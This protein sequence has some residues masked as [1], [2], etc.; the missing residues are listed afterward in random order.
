[1]VSDAQKEANKRWRL[2]NKEKYNELQ[3]TY[4]KTYRLLNSDTDAYRESHLKAN[5][6]Y[7]ERTNYYENNK[8]RI[9]LY[10]KEYYKNKKAQMNDAVNV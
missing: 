6:E 4:S 1:M 8:E 7:Q 2:A 3:R 10:A 9:L 5:K